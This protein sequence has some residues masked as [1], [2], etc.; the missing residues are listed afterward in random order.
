VD[1]SIEGTMDVQGDL[2]IGA[3]GTLIGEVKAVNIILAGKLEGNFVVSGKLEIASTGKIKGDVQ[4]SII[5][6]EEGGIMN[7][8][9]NMT[10]I[11]ADGEKVKR[12]GDKKKD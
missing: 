8:N 6:I 2:I 12:D 3:T 1:G 7:G 9:S 10:G 4:C 11:K 5:T